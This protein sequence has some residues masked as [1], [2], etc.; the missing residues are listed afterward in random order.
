MIHD[1]TRSEGGTM[2]QELRESVDRLLEEFM[3][4]VDALSYERHLQKGIAR[5]QL[6]CD[7]LALVDHE[8]LYV[9][10][11]LR[12]ENRSSTYIH[13]PDASWTSQKVMNSA[14][15]EF[16]F[17]DPFMIK[18]PASL[19]FDDSKRRQESLQK[20]A[21]DHI[22]SEFA[23][24]ANL[25]S[26]LRTKPI[27]GSVLAVGSNRTILLLLPFE[28]TS[29]GNREAIIEA[30]S[31]GKL[32]VVIADDIRKGKSAVKELW[33]SI[34]EARIVIADLTGPHPG[35]MYG[36]GIA[37]TVGKETVLIFPQNSNYLVDIP[38]TRR[39]EYENG[40]SGLNKL[41]KDLSD[42][43]KVLLEPMD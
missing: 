17:I 41:K 4:Q 30:A 26:L 42:I 39:I 21:G 2:P 33:T 3:V 9:V 6:P 15:W 24:F 14:Q 18:F 27:F 12:S 8:S 16:G 29:N 38:K 40:D 13:N 10:A 43:L 31:T 36:L 5:S 32:E 20:I 23:R 22:D 11:Q 25:L 35:V 34:N 7:V 37:H 19:L 1:G 28:E